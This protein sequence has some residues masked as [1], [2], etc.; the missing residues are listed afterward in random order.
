MVFLPPS[1]ANPASNKRIQ[2]CPTVQNCVALQIPREVYF[3][4]T[5]NSRDEYDNQCKS[6]R[7]AV[8]VSNRLKMFLRQCRAGTT[9]GVTR[10]D[11][12]RGKK[13][14]WRAHVRTWDISEANVLYWM[15][16]A[17]LLRLFSGL[18]SD[19]ATGELCPPRYAS[20][21][22]QQLCPRKVNTR[23]YFQQ[24]PSEV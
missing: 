8:T 13:Q 2:D 17:T 22:K 4:S 23:T 7:T 16:N 21:Y 1:S 5:T 9:R 12:A 20:G 18:L 11:G 6:R 3:R 10:L 24:F 14:V 19:S 15:K